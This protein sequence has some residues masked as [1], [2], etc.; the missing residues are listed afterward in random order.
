MTVVLGGE[1]AVPYTRNPLYAGLNSLWRVIF[2]TLKRAIL[3]GLRATDGYELRQVRKEAAISNAVCVVD[4]PGHGNGCKRSGKFERGCTTIS[5][6]FPSNYFLD[7]V[8]YR[9]TFLAIFEPEGLVS[10]THR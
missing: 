10:E 7:I 8:P 9:L 5:V 4:V 6:S 3:T 1:L 2:W